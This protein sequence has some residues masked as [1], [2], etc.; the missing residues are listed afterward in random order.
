MPSIAAIKKVRCRVLQVPV[1]LEG[2]A[3]TDADGRQDHHV[4]ELKLEGFDLSLTGFGEV[5][6]AGLLRTTRWNINRDDR[7]TGAPVFGINLAPRRRQAKAR[8]STAGAA[9]GFE[10]AWPPRSC[11]TPGWGAGKTSR[12]SR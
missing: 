8:R 10:P 11:G 2:C 6:L 4:A 5:E 12:W 7:G 9:A 1:Y 3:P